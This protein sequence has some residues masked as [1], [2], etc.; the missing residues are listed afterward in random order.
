LNAALRLVTAEAFDR[1]LDE[2]VAER[3]GNGDEGVSDEGASGTR[4]L[5]SVAT[6]RGRARTSVAGALAGWRE[7]HR[8]CRLGAVRHHRDERNNVD[9][10]DDDATEEDRRPPPADDD[11]GSSFVAGVRASVLGDDGAT[12]NAGAAVVA[13]ML[14]T[15]GCDVGPPA[16]DEQP[17]V[18]AEAP[19]PPFPEGVAA[20]GTPPAAGYRAVPCTS[21]LG[22]RFD[23][24]LS[25]RERLDRRRSQRHEKGQRSKQQKEALRQIQTLQ[26]WAARAEVTTV[27]T[28]AGRD[29]GA[30]VPLVSV[31]PP[32]SSSTGTMGAQRA[33]VAARLSSSSPRPPLRTRS[34][35]HLYPARVEA[36][37]GDAPLHTQL[38]QRLLR[39]VTDVSISGGLRGIIAGRVEAVRLQQHQ[40]GGQL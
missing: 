25:P 30:L 5:P 26:R 33:I 14:L 4:A 27:A 31:A 28:P 29:D 36:C 21:L 39:Q 8:D 11:G 32:A 10:N 1:Q 17:S 16:D 9:D 7:E 15:L 12:D 3:R 35:L 19:P 37:G 23:C 22:R 20:S 34:A 40:R 6:A 38:R 2:L 13:R 18:A 24:H